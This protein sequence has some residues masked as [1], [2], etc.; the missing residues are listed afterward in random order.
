MPTKK[1]IPKKI[2]KSKG[3]SQ[4]PKNA[5]QRAIVQ[6][7]KEEY[8]FSETPKRKK[9]APTVVFVQEN[10]PSILLTYSTTYNPRYV[11]LGMEYLEICYNSYVKRE[12][13]FNR[14]HNDHKTGRLVQERETLEDRDRYIPIVRLPEKGDFVMWLLM[15]H[16]V[17]ASYT[18]FDTWA[19]NDPEFKNVLD[20][21]K[22]AN[23]TFLQ[24]HSSNGIGKEG[25]QK[26]L[27][28]NNHGYKSDTA[29]NPGDNTVNIGIFQQIYQYIGEKKN[30]P[31]EQDAN[32]VPLIQKT[33]ESA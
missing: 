4:V 29:T 10:P 27:L 13:Y 23:A 2:P 8:K 28:I 18:K 5:K 20:M 11:Q 33:D 26:F 24:Q 1:Y 22:L 25:M 9:R 30:I 17:M 12:Q 14:I 6:A 3:L 15:E 32:Y 31:L 16:K 7:I 19:E 21:I